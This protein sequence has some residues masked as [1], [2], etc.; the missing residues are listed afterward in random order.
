METSTRPQDEIWA[1][2]REIVAAQ[3][4]A[5]ARQLQED[6]QRR[7][8][9][10]QRRRE[11]EQRRREDEQRRREEEQR[12]RDDEQRRQ[13]HERQRQAFE[14]KLQ[15]QELQRRELEVQRERERR[16][17][18]AS[19][20]RE[21]RETDRQLRELKEQ[22][23]GLGRKWGGF[24]EGLALP[25]MTR[26]LSDRFAMDVISPSV[27]L[28]RDGREIQLDVMAWANGSVN[29]AVIVEVKS[30]VRDDSLTQLLQ[31]LDR[32]QTWFPEHR[33]KHLFGILAGVDFPQEMKDA[34]LRAGVF[35]AL[36][37]D[38]VFELIDPPGFKP[39]DFHR[40][41]TESLQ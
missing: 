12:R 34:A 31:Q 5:T 18:D 23:G 33:D 16:E 8:E 25:S 20:E 30:H 6:E 7:R 4:E 11:N 35:P 2:L 27:R 24:T 14:R 38:E 40:P 21:R 19:R 29:T 26:I 17:A 41:L 13:E 28:R 36:I 10:E 3:Q 9:E 22:I 37:Q 39:K 32:F 1:M 15:E